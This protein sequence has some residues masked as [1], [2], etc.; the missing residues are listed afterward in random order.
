MLRIFYLAQW[1]LFVGSRN[2]TNCS[3]KTKTFMNDTQNFLIHSIEMFIKGPNY[4]QLAPPMRQFYRFRKFFRWSRHLYLTFGAFTSVAKSL[5]A[6]QDKTLFFSSPFSIYIRIPGPDRM[7]TGTHAHLTQRPVLGHHEQSWLHF[8][9]HKKKKKIENKNTMQDNSRWAN[10]FP[11]KTHLQSFSLPSP[12][13]LFCCLL[14]AFS[15]F[16]F[17]SI[18]RPSRGRKGK[19][20]QVFDR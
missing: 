17:R 5:R 10:P 3:H 9:S 13:P 14:S 4:G 11:N 1:D 18:T 12:F 2:L 19:R 7:C 6:E 15:K 8:P 20:K 16:G